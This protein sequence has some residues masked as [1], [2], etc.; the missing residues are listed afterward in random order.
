[1]TSRGVSGN[2]NTGINPYTTFSQ[3]PS[4]I[5]F[6]KQGDGT[7]PRGLS[8]TNFNN[9]MQNTELI[10]T[11][12]DVFRLLGSGQ[13]TYNLLAHDRQTL[14]F[15]LS[16]GIDAYN[17]HA[18][19]ISPA[20]AYIEQTN[21]NPGTLVNNNAN[22]FTGNIN[23]NFTHRLIRDMFTATTS[24][25][26]GQV[27][28]NVDIIGNTG[29]GVFP[30]CHQRRVGDADFHDGESG[31]RQIAVDLRTGRVPDDGRKTAAHSGC[32]R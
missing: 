18:R 16:G 17:D 27:R 3:V 15:T 9:P 5:D 11:P 26:I 24:A 4:F 28:R 22:I 10:K 19:I 25:G 30:G 13:L 21:A 20:T 29:R 7:Y 31:Y 1:L 6:Q 14:D 32:K 2:D 12:E 8:V 23:A